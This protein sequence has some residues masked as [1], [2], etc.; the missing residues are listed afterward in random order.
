M[1]RDW[2]VMGWFNRRDREPA[3]PVRQLSAADVEAVRGA[4]DSRGLIT[5]VKV[6]RERTAL[7]LK[8]AKEVAEAI[9]DGRYTPAP[10]APSTSDLASRARQLK[11]AG[12]WHGA[13]AAVMA[14]TG[15]TRAEADRFVDA[16]EA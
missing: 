13:A 16:L 3:Q 12:E 1:L 5:A 9:R 2:L 7:G 11:A 10:G 15:M 8:E 4:L 6:V 14:E